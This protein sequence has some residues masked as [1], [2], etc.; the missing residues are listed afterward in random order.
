[1]PV[2]TTAIVYVPAS[3][4]KDVTESGKPVE[5]LAGVQF[6]NFDNGRALFEVGSGTYRFASA[7]KP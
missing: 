1:M 6:L 5:H 7:I 4:V 2:N 3:D